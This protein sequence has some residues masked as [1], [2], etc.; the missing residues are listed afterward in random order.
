MKPKRR[1]E[2]GPVITHRA[3]RILGATYRVR[4]GDTWNHNSSR[5]LFSSMTWHAITFRKGRKSPSLKPASDIAHLYFAEQT[6]L[7]NKV[8][9]I[10]RTISTDTAL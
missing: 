8:T 2:N 6:L 5:F 7:R 9:Q 1:K 4:T 10:V 3:V